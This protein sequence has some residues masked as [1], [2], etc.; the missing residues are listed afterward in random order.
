MKVTLSLLIVGVLLAA[1]GVGWYVDANSQFDPH[2]AGVGAAAGLA[3][4]GGGI[5]VTGWIMMLV[6]RRSLAVKNK[7]ELVKEL[8]EKIWGV[9][10]IP[11][12][13]VD[14]D[15]LQA[16]HDLAD[17]VAEG[18]GEVLYKQLKEIEDR[19]NKLE[20]R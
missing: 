10:L 9:H 4:F 8:K 5:A 17:K 13:K 3:V 2:F 12:R 11:K 20:G 1:W 16:Q 18:I 6:K 14:P 19:L 15:Q 7:S